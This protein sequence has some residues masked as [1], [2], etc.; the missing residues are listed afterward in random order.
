MSPRHSKSELV[1][2]ATVLTIALPSIGNAI[3]WCS[4]SDIARLLFARSHV[5][6]FWS[7]PPKGPSVSRLL[8]P[9][10]DFTVAEEG[11]SYSVLTPLH[12]QQARIREELPPFA[13]TPFAPQRTAC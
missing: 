10:L 11:Y 5:R 12:L 9:I 1:G 13:P 6:L 8:S 2:K 7:K 3:L 4:S